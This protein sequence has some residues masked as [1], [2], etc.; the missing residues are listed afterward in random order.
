M[1][2]GICLMTVS[3]IAASGAVAEHFV[4]EDPCKD[5]AQGKSGDDQDGSGKP[6][7]GN[8]QGHDPQ[9]IDRTV[10]IKTW[11]HDHDGWY[12]DGDPWISCLPWP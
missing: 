11:N 8:I 10:K 2:A 9:V 5:Q 6:G 3:D 4:R 1:G 12:G 7:C